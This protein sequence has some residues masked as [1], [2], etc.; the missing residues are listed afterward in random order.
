AAECGNDLIYEWALAAGSLEWFGP[1]E[2]RLG[3]AP[4]EVPRT[5]AA[6]ERLL[7]PQDADEVAAAVDAHLAGRG[8]FLRE[9]RIR[10]KD[11]SYRRWS[12]RGTAITGADGR[13]GKWIGTTSDVTEARR[14]EEALRTKEEQL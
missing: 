1:V 9:Y 10:C 4:G 5:R 6:W 13:P 8:P 2:K 14:S 7:H 3:F 11:G 12:D